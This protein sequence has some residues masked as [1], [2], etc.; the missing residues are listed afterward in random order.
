MWLAGVDPKAAAYLGRNLFRTIREWYP[1]KKIYPAV[2]PDEQFL[3]SFDPL[4]DGP[5]LLEQ[6]NCDGL[7]IDTFNK[8][9]G[10]RL[11]SLLHN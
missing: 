9:I 6:I 8:I 3:I 10:K 1:E 5:V 7:L 11:T 4:T 2:F